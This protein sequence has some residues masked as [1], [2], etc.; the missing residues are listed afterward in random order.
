MFFKLKV[1]L[2]RSL[3]N[4][5]EKQNKNKISEYSKKDMTNNRQNDDTLE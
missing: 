4:L 1:N 2:E 3:F 5:K